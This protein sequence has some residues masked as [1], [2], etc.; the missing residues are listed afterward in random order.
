MVEENNIWTEDEDTQRD[1]Y[2]TFTACGENYGISISCV[3]EI[4]GLSKIAEVPETAS[5]V[6]GLINLRGKI[7]PVIDVRMR[8]GK[9]PLEYNDRTCV[10]V[11]TVNKTVV[12]LIVDKIAEVCTVEQDQI[13]PPPTVVNN[14]GQTRFIYGIVRSEDEVT[15]LIDPARLISD[16]DQE[17]L[18]NLA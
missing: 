1:K 6:R 17:A 16:E 12:G 9:E 7:I 8:F 3:N 15:M 13:V 5:Y 11:I 14:S 18:R 4:V 2:M 10:I